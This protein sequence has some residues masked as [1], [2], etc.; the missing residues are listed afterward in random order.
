MASNLEISEE[1]PFKSRY[2]DVHGSEIHYVEEGS[3][4]RS[5]FF[6]AI[7]LLPICGAT[8]FPI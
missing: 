7:P 4:T 2:I 1:F 3:G 6:T 8:L 5:C